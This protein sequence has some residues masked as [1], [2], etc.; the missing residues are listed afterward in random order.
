MW[1]RTVR[2]LLPLHCLLAFSA[3]ISRREL[4]PYGE[5]KGDVLLQE[6][7]D[8]TSEVVK[9]SQ[10][11]LFYE[12]QFS[13]LY[14]GTNGIISTQ[15]FPRETQ[16]V[17]DGF[18]TDFPVIAPFLSDIDTSNGKGKIFYRQ[19]N[20]EP[21]LNHAAREIQ[22]GFPEAT[23]I[24]N[25][26]FLVTWE[27]VGTY[28]EVTRHSA[29]SDR[30]NTFQA[31]LA[32]DHS[33]AYAIFLYPEDGLQFFGTRPKES[34]NVHIELPA[35]VGFSRSEA[36]PYYSVTS[37]E[38][39]VKNLYQTGNVGVP[40]IWVFHIGSIWELDNV[41][42]AK[43]F[44]APANEQS[45][46][47]SHTSFPEHRLFENHENED[48]IDYPESFYEESEDELEDNTSDATPTHETHQ[49][50]DSNT[51]NQGYLDI[52][53]Q[54]SKLT[55]AEDEQK[56]T[57]SAVLSSS[58]QNPNWTPYTP[59]ESETDRDGPLQE[60]Q[61]QTGENLD[62]TREDTLLTDDLPSHNA[63]DSI[64]SNSEDLPIYPESAV[65]VGSH[66]EQENNFER[67]RQTD[68]DPGLQT[69]VFSFKP[70]GKETCERNHGRCSRFAFCA[71]YSTGFC[72]HCQEDYYGNGVHCL[73]RGAPH[74]VNGKVSG[75]ILV[76]QTPVNFIDADLHAYIVANDGRAYTAISNVPDPASW[77]LTPL[78]PIGGLFG[79]LFA[80]EKPGFQNGFSFTGAKFVHNID[81]TFYPGEEAI[82][83]TQTA[84][85]FDSEG[86]MNV[87]TAIQ[88][89]IPYIPE[90]STIKLSPYT[91]LYQYSGSVVTSTAYRE[92]T[93][94]SESN[95]EQKLSYRLR[96]NVTY[97]E[98]SHSQKQ[99]VSAQKLYVDRVFALYNKE[100]KVLRYAITNYIGSVH[101]STGEED[102]K[103]N[104][105]YDGTHLCDT[106]AKC[107]PG[108]GLEYICVCASGYQGDGRDCTDV[109]ECEV[110]FTRCGQNTVCVNLQGSYR[111]ECASGFTLSGDEHNCILASSINPCEDGRHMCNRDTSRCVPHGDGVY[112]CQCFPGF[113][114]SGEKCVD[115]DEC[116]EHRCHPDA[117]CTNT[118]GSFSC[119]CNSG[120]EGDG[121][122][123][124]QILDPEPLRTPCLEK[125]QQLLGQL[126]P[127]GPRPV[128]G[129]FVPE[130]DAEGNY[131]PLQCHGSTGHCWCVDKLGEEV[132]ET[133]TP[134]GRPSPNCGDKGPEPLRTPCLEKRQQ[135]LG[136]LHPRG[137]RPV[138]GQFVPE[139]DAEGNY[140]PLQCHGSTGH[141]WCVDKLGEEIAGTRTQPGRT[142]PN[143][144]DKGPE[145]LRTPCL[146]K[147][148]QLLG[149]L[150]SR[151][152]HPIVGQFVPE[153]DVEGNYVPL[154]CH[155]STGHCW[156]VDKLGE[157]V[158][159]TRTPPGR[160][161]PNCGDT[162]PT[163]R[164]QTVCERWKQSLIEHY[165][166]KPSGE[167][168]VPQCDQYGDFSPL[169]CHGNSGYCWCVDKEGREIE[170]SRTEPGM[171]PA[172]IPTVAPPTMH[173]TPRPDVTPPATGTFL[174]YAQG[175]QIGYLPL[176]GTRLHKDKARTLLSLHGSIVVGIDYDCHE[177]MV[178]WTDVAGRTINRA[179]LEPGAEAEIIINTG[180]M[181][182][183]GLAID[184]LR[185]TLFW[186]D[187]GLDKIESSRLDGTERKIL[188]DTQLVNPRAITVDAVRGNLYWTDWNREAPKIE[189]SFVDGSNRR[190]LVNDNIGLPNGLTF[191]PFSKQVCW[192]DAG[193]KKLECI[194]SDGTGRR[195]IQSNLNYP[196]S[197]VAYANH[198]YHTDWRRDGVISIKKDTGHIV[199]E[200]LPEQRSHLYGITAVYPYCPSGRK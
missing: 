148:Q 192:A 66:P 73:P 53:D 143:C 181:S 51:G 39:S 109:N 167:H 87:K 27:N 5:L 149:Q 42:P 195:V 135:L 34:Y 43:F 116:T 68:A 50:G 198:F 55:H 36:G 80:L 81:V 88:G 31:V 30:R 64:P 48:S 8:E 104:P 186:T 56:A 190:I 82:H 174:L 98:C 132:A 111:C 166:G 100:E 17:D 95:E 151:G 170:G 40:G 15:D 54:A 45:L 84:H 169:Q 16:Y 83:I 189:S 74:R 197:V 119:R 32:Y 200:Y 127:R 86:Y 69:D 89:K 176:N 152:P 140:V 139:C 85:G 196:F 103:V 13:N 138:V 92:Y 177:K 145:P 62:L 179:S 96:Q 94:L 120:Y 112:T 52:D 172:C 76:G 102:L 133:R 163:Q 164:P 110:G 114:M 134:P 75:N 123:C 153:C 141:C 97:Q 37:N 130:C 20:S 175:Q 46:E 21:V 44:G 35:R 144:A 125:R 9:L 185:R 137:S 121:F 122:Q 99:S 14:V 182:T 41:I 108:S 173:P 124:T 118:L 115:V 61:I 60:P 162:E 29:S 188:F 199:E 106:R 154:Q 165:G 19:D 10:P 183:E 136:Q 187:S 33:D 113:I 47:N 159:G 155:G 180:L 71:D 7:D 77:S 178:Y 184:Y 105:C 28:E 147:R 78:A 79:W 193:T 117:S 142:S 156:C 67:G 4:F 171:T 91:E 25:H 38:Q 57:S 2:L 58:H 158:A 168:Y 72:C 101:D 194:L 18:P 63:P 24:P 3:A 70:A 107:Q 1:D 93:V 26:A 6:G 11:L 65:L 157:E 131:V 12:A 191:D 161:S 146:E 160:P 23:F 128:V 59:S 22:R 129:Q 150:H 126:H 90:T 49:E